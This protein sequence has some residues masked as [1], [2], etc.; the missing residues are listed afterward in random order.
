MHC[1]QKPTVIQL[2]S[3]K[4]GFIGWAHY[5]HRDRKPGGTMESLIKKELEGSWMVIWFVWHILRKGW[6]KQS[7]AVNWVLSG[8]QSNTLIGYHNHFSLEGKIKE[9]VGKEPVITVLGETAFDSVYDFT[10]ILFI[11]KLRNDYRV[12]CHLFPLITD[13]EQPHAG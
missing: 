1:C 9:A 4:I 2:Q 7:F 3:N 10:V 11:V 8:S 6:E 5:N 13:P 12:V